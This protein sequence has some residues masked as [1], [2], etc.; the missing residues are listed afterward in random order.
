MYA[1]AER[2]GQTTVDA[3]PLT[4]EM[5]VERTPPPSAEWETSFSARARADLVKLGG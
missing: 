5:R 4:S 2:R 3:L 1:A